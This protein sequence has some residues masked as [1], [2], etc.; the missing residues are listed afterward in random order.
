MNR[1]VDTTEAMLNLLE[2]E[3]LRTLKGAN[4]TT[5]VHM[6]HHMVDPQYRVLKIQDALHHL[7]ASGCKNT[8]IY[9]AFVR[10]EWAALNLILPQLNKLDEKEKTH[11]LRGM[12]DRF[13]AI[14]YA[15]ITVSEALC[16]EKTSHYHD[17]L[18][19]AQAREAW[20]IKQQ[21]SFY[22]LFDEM[23]VRATVTVSAWNTDH[24]LHSNITPELARVFSADPEMR[25]A[26]IDC[27]Q[28]GFRLKV[29]VD[30][31]SSK[32]VRFKVVT[33]DASGVALRKEVRIG[34]EEHQPVKILSASKLICP[35]QLTEISQKGLGLTA[36]QELPFVAGEK[37]TCQTQIG[38]INVNHISEVVWVQSFQKGGRF[39]LTI[40]FDK[41]ICRQLNSEILDLQRKKIVRLS[42]LGMPPAFHAYKA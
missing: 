17:P 2:K 3:M 34:L 42:R 10:C 23:P 25:Y 14:K 29:M 12:V 1:T 16:D 8:E 21:V 24:I 7:I 15:L 39:A 11:Q 9:T 28:P 19:L 6:A 5:I 13:H 27:P 20:M 35:A 26:Y 32:R 36:Q 40:E 30:N 22:N 41:A 38:K 33:V 18:I 37:F 4:T 31:V